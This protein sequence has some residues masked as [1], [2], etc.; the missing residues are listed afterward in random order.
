MNVHVHTHSV[1]TVVFSHT[2]E[3]WF[4]DQPPPRHQEPVGDYRGW[5]THPDGAA[6][7]GSAHTHAHTHTLNPNSDLLN[8]A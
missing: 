6:V 3:F 2:G 7:H 1:M 5:R 4:P 8:Q